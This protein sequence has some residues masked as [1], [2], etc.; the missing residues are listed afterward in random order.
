MMEKQGERP[1]HLHRTD[2]VEMAVCKCLW[3]LV[4]VSDF[5][6][7]IIFKLVTRWHRHQCAWGLH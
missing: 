4:Q 7:D 1:Y 5:D 6:C 2:E 3:L